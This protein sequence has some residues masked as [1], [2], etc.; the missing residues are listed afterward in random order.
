MHTREYEFEINQDNES[1]ETIRRNK[2]IK[3][4]QENIK[5]YGVLSD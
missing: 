2:N 5:K 3:L 4:I 1:E